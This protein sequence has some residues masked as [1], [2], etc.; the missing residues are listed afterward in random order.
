MFETFGFI[1][2]LYVIIAIMIVIAPVFIWQHAASINKKVAAQL[3]LLQSLSESIEKIAAQP[4]PTQRRMA[5]CPHCAKQIELV[6]EKGEMFCPRCGGKI[7][8]V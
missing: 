1:G 2:L 3:K 5:Q 7:E 6:G 4:Q 8:L